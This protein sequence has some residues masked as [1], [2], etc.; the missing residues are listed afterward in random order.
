[1]IY[2]NTMPINSWDEPQETQPELVEIEVMESQLSLG[3]TCGTYGWILAYKIIK[4][5]MTR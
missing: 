2:M 3:L 4:M 5:K 1:M